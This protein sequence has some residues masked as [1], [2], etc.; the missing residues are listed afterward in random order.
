MTGKQ[1][2][3]TLIAQFIEKR[4]Q[5]ILDRLAQIGITFKNHKE[6]VLFAKNRLTL[7][8]SDNK[9]ALFLDYHSDNR[10]MICWW[11]EGADYEVKFEN[12]KY[13]ATIKSN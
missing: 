9:R 1:I 7:I 3:K 10:R 2:H 6:K 12:N 13:T 11:L 4:E 8:K 5:Q